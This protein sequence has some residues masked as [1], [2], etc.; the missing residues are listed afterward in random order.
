[1]KT[2]I[3]LFLANLIVCLSIYLFK[4]YEIENLKKKNEIHQQVER[5]AIQ[6]FPDVDAYLKLFPKSNYINNRFIAT[7]NNFA[8]KFYICNLPKFTITNKIISFL[9]SPT[10]EAYKLIL[11]KNTAEVGNKRILTMLEIENEILNQKFTPLG[12]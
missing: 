11:Q 12:Q 5:A 6:K 9:G 3:I 8:N 4:E 2:Y 1:M 7:P 10:F